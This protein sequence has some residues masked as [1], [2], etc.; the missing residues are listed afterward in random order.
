[1]ET[2]IEISG[3]P[4]NFITENGTTRLRFDSQTTASDDTACQTL[5]IPEIWLITRSNGVPLFALEPELCDKPFRILTATQLYAEKIQWFEPLADF[6]RNC[7]WVNPISSVEG[8][9][10]YGAFKHHSWQSI[11][12]FAI[13]DRPAL[14]FHRGMPGD[15]KKQK[16][17]GDEYLLCLVEGAPYWTD[18]LGQIPYAVDTF[19]LYW[20]QTNDRD[21]SMRKTGATGLEWANGNWKRR[22]SWHP[23]CIR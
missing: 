12:N 22:G 16:T 4:Y 6:Y 9:A 21:W 1:M 17:G 11:I 23:K 8:S 13:V 3:A 2:I 20:Q 18:A 7:L 5:V 10:A 14:M 19:R 15:W